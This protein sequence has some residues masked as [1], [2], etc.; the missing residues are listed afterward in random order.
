[1]RRKKREEEVWSVV[2]AG[3]PSSRM[4]REEEI[5][6]GS[7]AIEGSTHLDAIDT[8]EDLSYQI[9]TIFHASA[10]TPDIIFQAH[11]LDLESGLDLLL[12]RPFPR[13]TISY[14]DKK[15]CFL[16]IN[17]Q[18]SISA[19]SQIDPIERDCRLTGP[20]SILWILSPSSALV[21]IFVCVLFI[22]ARYP[23]FLG[24][25]SIVRNGNDKVG[26]IRR[27]W[28]ARSPP[29]QTLQ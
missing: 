14:S 22:A 19:Y 4:R 26:K 7:R 10:R 29:K 17:S 18:L 15:D 5:E 2:S 12:S 3:S 11:D 25:E 6:K 8:L 1:M 20:A 24:R 27:K 28:T 21:S 16:V 13:T 9:Q 23:V